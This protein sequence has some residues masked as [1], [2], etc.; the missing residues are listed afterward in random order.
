MR[1]A[2]NCDQHGRLLPRGLSPNTQSRHLFAASHR[3]Q[4]EETSHRSDVMDL[5]RG[6]EVGSKGE[7]GQS[8]NH[9]DES[10]LTQAP[11]ESHSRQV[12]WGQ[13]KEPIE[14]HAIFQPLEIAADGFLSQ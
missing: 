13:K 12:E 11:K 4:N 9:P 14:A 2:K 1:A 7:D 10:I 8:C 5:K 6:E 3:Y